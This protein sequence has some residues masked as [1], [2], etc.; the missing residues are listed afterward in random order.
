M[1]QSAVDPDQSTID[2]RHLPPVNLPGPAGAAP[3]TPALPA[4][5]FSLRILALLCIGLPLLVYAVVGAARYQ[6]IRS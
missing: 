2:P 3:T 4:P 1:P 6:Q 5:L